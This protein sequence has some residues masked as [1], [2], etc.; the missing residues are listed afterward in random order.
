MVRL[1]EIRQLYQVEGADGDDA[2]DRSTN[3][4]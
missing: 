1:V 3:A 2:A 4:V